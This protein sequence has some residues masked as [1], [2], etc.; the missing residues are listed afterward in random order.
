MTL[1]N[2]R[3][4]FLRLQSMTPCVFGLIFASLRLVV[5]LLV[6]SVDGIFG[7]RVEPR[8]LFTQR[9]R[10]LR[11]WSIASGDFGQITAN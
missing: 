3:H 11:L 1:L 7:M 2:Q 9:H 4:R 8:P 5:P 10:F 6:P